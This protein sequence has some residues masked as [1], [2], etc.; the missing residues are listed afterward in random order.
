MAQI[1]HITIIVSGMLLAI[2]LV[3]ACLTDFRDR[4]ISNK[5]VVIG[6]LTGIGL[7]ILFPKGA[8][9]FSTAAGSLGT[10]N[11]L[12]G[13]AA[14]L[15]LMMPFYLLRA[16]GA[17]DVKLMAMIGAFLG[18]ESVL[19]AV[20]M[21]CLSGGILAIVVA[22]WKGVFRRTIANMH[23]ITTHTI[24]NALS[25]H[26]PPIGTLSSSTVKLPYALAITAGTVLQII[27]ARDGHAI[28]S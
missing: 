3:T 2:L 21:T 27:L 20:L 28:F 1:N 4:R 18:P 10:M 8:G 17:G 7:H 5:L 13:C 16:M 26:R 25:G 22:V 14:G 15:G 9:L 12:Y 23:L 24:M 19:D 11:A 6:T